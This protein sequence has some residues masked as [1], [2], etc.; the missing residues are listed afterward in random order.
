MNKKAFILIELIITIAIVSILAAVAFVSVNPAKRIGDTKDDERLAE[1]I[2][3]K[4]A[5][6]KYTTDKLGLPTSIEGKENHIPNTD[7]AVK[8]GD[9]DDSTRI[10]DGK[11]DEVAIWDRALLEEEVLAIYN[12]QK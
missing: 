7:K 9:G 1:A 3:I 10:L 6:E 12:L 8:I 2:S 11:M 5:I 4:A